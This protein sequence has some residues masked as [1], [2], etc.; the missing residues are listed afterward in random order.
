VRG[1]DLPARSPQH[2]VT[3][4]SG[5]IR[6]GI[7]GW[8]YAPWRGVF[9]PEGLP[10]HA[11]LAFAAER[12]RSIEVNGTFYRLQRP[13]DFERWDSQTPA[14]FVFALK[15]PRYITHMLKMRR[16]TAPL[17]NF[18]ASGPLR[19]G[20]KL[21]PLLWQFPPALRF[22]AARFRAFL[23]RLPHDT[24]AALA[25]ARRHDARVS[26]RSWLH[27][28]VSQQLRH[29]VE[30]RHESF[31]DMAFI[32][33][34][35]EHNVALVCAD[36]V[37]WPLLMDLT[38]D[39]VYCRLHGSRQLYSSG[40]GPAAL[41]TWARRVRAWAAGREAP[42][43][44]RAGGPTPPRSGGRD[45]YLYFDNDAKVRAPADAAALIRALNGARRR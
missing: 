38:A 23:E 21:G 39:F 27:C 8:H 14:N 20:A 35:R 29:A 37:E 13:E 18:L 16:L 11:Q 10:A 26:R 7:S 36:T 31:R 19:L 2:A 15:G 32:D 12:F 30:I 44:Q 40:Y 3:R 17:A 25:L 34:L 6:I 22:D 33:L 45:V 43:A 5:E 9:Y 28:E 4:R 42:A 41:A 1:R 24:K